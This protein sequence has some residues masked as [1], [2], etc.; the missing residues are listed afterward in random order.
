MEPI[1]IDHKALSFMLKKVFDRQLGGKAALVLRQLVDEHDVVANSK[2]S[3][4]RARGGGQSSKAKGRRAVQEVRDLLL[5]LLP[6]LEADDFLVK[7][8]SM[9][10]TDLHLSPAA[11]KYFPFGIEVKAVEALNIWA[12]LAQARVNADKQALPP[13]VF[14]T[15][16]HAPMYVA[17][18]AEVFVPFVRTRCCDNG[19]FGDAHECQK[20]D[21]KVHE[22]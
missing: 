14:F 10:G 22:L 8:T 13:I 16:A 18:P 15:R 3:R 1:D 9:G 6:G 2:K 12:A 4:G 17:L 20:S 11:Q 21:G 7:A 5:R 19:Y